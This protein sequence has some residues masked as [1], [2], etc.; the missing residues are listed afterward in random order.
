MLMKSLMKNPILIVGILLMSTFLMNHYTYVGLWN[1]D[2]LK[3][4]SCKAVLVKL[5]RRVPSGWTTSCDK[6]NLYI[7]I[8]HQSAKN[9]PTDLKLIRSIVYRQLANSYSLVAS[10]SPLDNLER[11]DWVSIRYVHPKIEV[12]GRSRGQFVAKFATIKN[13]EM[14]K[15]H[16]QATVEVKELIKK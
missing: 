11:T 4:T 2:R 5:N 16:L 8:A 1:K 12:A 6:N 7:A 14:L 3:P 9:E 10:Y 15:K 13:K